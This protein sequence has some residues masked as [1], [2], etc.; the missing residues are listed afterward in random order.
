MANT[1]T[2]ISREIWSSLINT[3][4]NEKSIAPGLFSKKYEG[5]ARQGKT[6]HI[7]S[8]EAVT[9]GTYT[10]GSDISIQNITPTKVDLTIDQFKYYAFGVDDVQELLVNPKMAALQVP[11]A[12]ANL[13]ENIDAALFAYLYANAGLQVDGSDAAT[14]GAGG[15]GIVLTEVTPTT[16]SEMMPGQVLAKTAQKLTTAKVPMDG[17]YF[18]MSPIF[19]E[20]LIVSKLISDTAHIGISSSALQSG[21]VAKLYGFDLFVSSQLTKASSKRHCVAGSLRGAAFAG[22]SEQRDVVKR[23]LQFGNIVKGLYVYGRIVTQANALVE[24]IIAEA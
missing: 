21:T 24:V 15:A 2:A 10:P 9:V 13:G 1:I 4:L 20:K 14:A 7:P 12:M 8:P 22:V 3:I 11:Q 5:E 17:R 16:T 18:V 23:E 19:L 6:V